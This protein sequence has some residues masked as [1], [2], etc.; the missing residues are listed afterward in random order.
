[1]NPFDLP[2]PQFLGLYAALFVA[3]LAVAVFL[4]WALRQPSDEPDPDSFN[5]APLD[6]AYLAGG[7]SLAVNAAVSRLAHQGALTASASQRKLFRKEGGALQR[8]ATA[9]EKAIFD[10]V[11][12]ISGTAI[13]DLRKEVTD[14]LTPLRQRLQEAGLVVSDDQAAMARWLPLLLLLAVPLFGL[15]KIVVGL[16]RDRPVSFLVIMCILSVV[17]A[18]VCVGRAVFRSRKGDR[19]LAVLREQNAALEYSSSRR[20]R[21]LAGDDLM[22]AVGLFGMGVLYGSPIADLE[23]ALRPK[24]GAST[25]GGGCSSGGGGGCGGG[26]GGGG[27]GGCGG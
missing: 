2:G 16:S 27:C 3:G 10:A 23:T 12:P 7:A 13:A 18:G 22:L 25:C 9:F 20:G 24:P 5:L 19:A 21:E 17:I 8:G 6:T 1:M 14:E 4:R 11:D 15:I 26:C